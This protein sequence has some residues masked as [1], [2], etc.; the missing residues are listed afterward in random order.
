MSNA[1]GIMSNVLGI[2]SNVL[3]IML[4]SGNRFA[5]SILSCYAHVYVSLC[6]GAF[7]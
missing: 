4:E 2:M 6:S 1:L 3:V 7:T 5:V